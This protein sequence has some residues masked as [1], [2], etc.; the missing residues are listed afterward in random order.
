VQNAAGTTALFIV[1]STNARL[2]V[3]PTA[4]DTVGTLLVLGNKTNAGD[5]TGVEGG[6]YYN[7]SM[8]QMRCYID[9]VWRACNTPSSLSWG[10]NFSDEFLDGLIDQ[11]H[12]TEDLA[13]TG[14]GATW[15]LPD[16]AYRPGQIS[17][18]TGT[19]TT[20][21]DILW[22]SGNGDYYIGGGEEIE[23]AINLPTLADVTND[24]VM[25]AGLCEVAT[26]DCDNGVYIEYDRSTST[27]WRFAT[28][29]GGTRTKTS[30]STAVSTGW[31]RFKIVVNSAG[32][33]ISYYMDGVSLGSA[34]TTN[35]P[36]SNSYYTQQ[37]FG[38][39]KTAGTTNRTVKVD[40]FQY[41]GNLSSPR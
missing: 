2:Y 39:R 25:R 9:S 34:I 24:Y 31:H 26:A 32:N 7:S 20:G 1:D 30:S 21:R 19:T 11:D 15:P 36:D 17:L 4:G 28:A 3:G 12:W 37:Y 35:I 10:V 41:R 22:S 14:A 27:N 29:K 38:I 33:S 13:G 8:K 23:F 40:Y 18:E 6:M 16:V 5:P